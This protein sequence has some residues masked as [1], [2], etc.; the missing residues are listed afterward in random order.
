MNYCCLYTFRAGAAA[1]L[2]GSEGLAVNVADGVCTVNVDPSLATGQA[3]VGI[4]VKAA[5]FN[6]GPVSVCVAGICQARAGA[7]ID[8]GTGGGSL[9]MP[10]GDG[11]MDPA[12]DGS[13]AVARYLGIVDAADGDWHDVCVGTTY[14]E[15]T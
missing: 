2:Q 5:E 7:A 14:Y 6:G 3:P 1:T 4:L 8:A 10:G 15:T 13:F 12:T 11:R 9:L